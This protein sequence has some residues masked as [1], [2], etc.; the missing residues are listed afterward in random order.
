MKWVQSPI[1]SSIFLLGKTI[2]GTDFPF[3]VESF[4]AVTLKFFRKRSGNRFIFRGVEKK[5]AGCCFHTI[6]FWLLSNH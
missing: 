6:I 2:S 3:V 1:P 4:Y 5:R